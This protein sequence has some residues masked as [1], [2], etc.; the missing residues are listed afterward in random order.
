MTEHPAFPASGS[1]GQWV[2]ASE[3]LRNLIISEH[4]HIVILVDDTLRAIR[5]AVYLV[6]AVTFGLGMIGAPAIPTFCRQPHH[7]VSVHQSIICILL[8]GS[9]IMDDC[10]LIDLRLR[11]GSGLVRDGIAVEFLP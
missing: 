8:D 1:A 5:P 4:Q 3:D 9:Q 2:R 11:P 6:H 10:W 7:P